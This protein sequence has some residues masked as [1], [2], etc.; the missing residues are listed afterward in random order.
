MLARV[1]VARRAAVHPHQRHHR[2]AH[3]VRRDPV[4]TIAVVHKK[5]NNEDYPTFFAMSVD[6]S[7]AT[8]TARPTTSGSTSL[9]TFSTRRLDPSRPPL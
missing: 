9:S 3:F 4:P 2:R 5:I 7:D 8:S 1:G 6:F